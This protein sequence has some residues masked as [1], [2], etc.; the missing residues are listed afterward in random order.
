[1]LKFHFYI[2]KII[3]NISDY[4]NYN[5]SIQIEFANIFFLL[6]F[7]AVLYYRFLCKQDVVKIRFLFLF[8]LTLSV[9]TGKLVAK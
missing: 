2:S 7:Y 8:F 9:M 6:D 4:L 3:Q 1:M 5:L